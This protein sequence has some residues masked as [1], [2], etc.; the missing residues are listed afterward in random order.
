M[1]SGFFGNKRPTRIFTTAITTSATYTTSASVGPTTAYTFPAQAFCVAYAYSES[2][3]LGSAGTAQVAFTYTP[4]VGGAVTTSSPSITLNANV[5]TSVQVPFTPFLAKSGSTFTYTLVWSGVTG[6][7]V[8]AYA[9]V[10][11][12]F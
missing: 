9:V 6:S 2:T 1:A 8:A 12:Q 4:P 3:A 11:E 10:L 5:G 7:A